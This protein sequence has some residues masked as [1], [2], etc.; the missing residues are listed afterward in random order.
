MPKIDG[1]QSGAARESPCDLREEILQVREARSAGISVQPFWKVD[2]WH[3]QPVDWF[4]DG[5]GHGSMGVG[6]TCGSG[7]LEPIDIDGSIV[8]FGPRVSSNQQIQGFESELL[9]RSM[10]NL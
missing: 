6:M 2:A 5:M 7:Q 3:L 4:V 8:R 9:I 10:A 1:K